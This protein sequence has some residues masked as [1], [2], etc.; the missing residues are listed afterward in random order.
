ME[1]LDY[2]LVHLAESV[3]TIGEQLVDDLIAGVKHV[4]FID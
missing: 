2:Q 3:D 1:R 4:V